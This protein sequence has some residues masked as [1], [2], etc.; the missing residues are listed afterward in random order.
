M[1]AMLTERKCH[2]VL[3]VHPMI[4]QIFLQDEV[5]SHKDEIIRWVE[6]RLGPIAATGID[7][8][9][10]L[11]APISLYHF[12]MR[13]VC[14]YHFWELSAPS[15][16]VLPLLF[17]T[18]VWLIAHHFYMR[19]ARAV[20]VKRHAFFVPPHEHL[21]VSVVAERRHKAEN[22]KTVFDKWQD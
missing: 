12:Q 15:P 6:N 1:S 14:A 4:K 17:P 10:H 5:R 20:P 21:R 22:A 18:T 2:A 13:T 16:P 11:H 9:S 3:R 7:F 8:V 19:T